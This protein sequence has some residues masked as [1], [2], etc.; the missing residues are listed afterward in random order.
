MPGEVP[1]A[2]VAEVRKMLVCYLYA[3]LCYTVLCC[4]ILCCT[5]CCAMLCCAMLH[6]AILRFAAML[7]CA[8]IYFNHVSHILR[9]RFTV[10]QPGR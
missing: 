9:S 3:V 1:A 7:C 4:A 5:L 2:N 6:C 8:M 10:R